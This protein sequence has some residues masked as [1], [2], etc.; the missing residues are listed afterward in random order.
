VPQETTVALRVS[1]TR[2]VAITHAAQR[3]REA[4]HPRS[5]WTGRRPAAAA[6]ARHW[7]ERCKGRC[8]ET[9]QH[10][11]GRR[12]AAP[13]ARVPVARGRTWRVRPPAAASRT[14]SSAACGGLGA[15]EQSAA[16][17]GVAAA[18]GP[19]RAAAWAGGAAGAR[20]RE[21]SGGGCAEDVPLAGTRHRKRA[22]RLRRACAAR[23]SGSRAA[24][25]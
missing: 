25:R 15:E 9:S 16:S 11:I 4:P 17:R 2:R 5:A 19:K 7:Q 20:A 24:R 1:T 22:L 13:R 3:S 14:G 18:D 10:G 12:I 23:G 6:A 8:Q 21:A